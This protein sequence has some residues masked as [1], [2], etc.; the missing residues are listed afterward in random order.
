VLLQG[1]FRES[2]RCRVFISTGI[3]DVPAGLGH[4]RMA[5]TACVR[6]TLGGVAMRRAPRAWA[7]LR[8]SGRLSDLFCTS[9][10]RPFAGRRVRFPQPPSI[11]SRIADSSSSCY[12][13][14]QV[15][16]HALLDK[17]WLVVRRLV[18]ESA[19]VGLLGGARSHSL[20]TEGAE[21]LP[22]WDP[23]TSCPR[24]L[25][26]TTCGVPSSRWAQG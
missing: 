21:A 10:R 6:C 2:T 11:G 7:R 25:L 12:R 24:W 16:A 8:R 3:G 19:R 23:P 1:F 14:V 26:N 22:R 15:D 18:H 20:G 17:S 4:T 13:V 5:G 9:P